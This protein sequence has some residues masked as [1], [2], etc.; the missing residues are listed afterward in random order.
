MNNSNS[1]LLS[2]VVY[3]KQE[4][5]ANAKVSAGQQCVYYMYEGPCP[6]VKKCTANQ[7]KE[8]HNVEKYTLNRLK[9]RIIAYCVTTMSLAMGLSFV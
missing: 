7:R 6:I 3:R 2:F 5:L 4:S 9:T 8:H 1:R